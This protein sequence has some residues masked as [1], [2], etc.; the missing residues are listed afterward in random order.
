MGFRLSGWYISKDS[1]S[2]NEVNDILSIKNRILV[3]GES[4]SADYYAD[5]EEK[6]WPRQLETMIKD[7]GF[8]IKVFNEARAGTNTGFILA[9]LDLLLD[10]Y[11]PHIVISMMGINDTGNFF[12]KP[13][14]LGN[15]LSRFFQE[16]RIYKLVSW[17]LS[18]KKL[19]KVDHREG[20]VFTNSDYGKNLL[21]TLC[22]SMK[23]EEIVEVIENKF[24]SKEDKGLAYLD[25]FL[26][27]EKNRVPFHPFQSR[28]IEKSYENFP[29]NTNIMFWFLKDNVRFNRM[30]T[31]MRAV[32]EASL[33]GTELPDKVLN[34][35]ASSLE[36]NNVETNHREEIRDLFYMFE[37][38]REKKM[39]DATTWHYQM[40]ARK[41]LTRGIKLI[42]MQ[43]PTMP[44]EE[45]KN[46]LPNWQK[47]DFISNRE[48]FEKAL[49]KNS[50]DEIFID[51][52]KENWGHMSTLGHSIISKEL[53]PVVS[54]H[55]MK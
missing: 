52:F 16:L 54:K 35:L 44:I 20:P 37:V 11:K 39:I 48:N 42:A 38:S 5:D 45:L 23:F 9:D 40:L 13:D 2:R 46:K 29:S 15:K 26:C 51:K 24:N 50:Y 8:S 17:A 19:L 53:Y 6:S 34:F 18:S 1:H 3:L 32:R 30:E 10:K 36:M 12:Y 27:L 55:L 4:T 28:L 21:M 33:Y 14:K 49:K 43:Y 25:V 22:S 7:R 47:V 31:Y 41:T